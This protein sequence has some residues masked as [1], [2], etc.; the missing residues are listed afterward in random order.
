MRS[1]PEYSS[2]GVRC[3]FGGTSAVTSPIPIRTRGAQ[4]LTSPAEPPSVTKCVNEYER[5]RRAGRTASWR[6]RFCSGRYNAPSNWEG[7]DWL[8]L[9]G[10]KG[11]PVTS[12]SDFDVIV[13]GGGG[14]GLAAAAA[15]AESGASV[16]V[17]EAAAATGG[18]PAPRRGAF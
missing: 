16:L 11:G 8:G 17:G 13:V 4:P 2:A 15:A 10:R 14:G 3:E 9:G 1:V 6:S 12:A 5:E 7:L 18:A